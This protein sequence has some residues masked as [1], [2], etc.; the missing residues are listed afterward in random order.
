MKSLSAK[1]VAVKSDERLH[2]KLANEGL[3]SRREIESWIKDG[4]LSV[5]GKT[6]Q[7][8]QTWRAGMNLTLDGKLLHLSQKKNE[9]RVLLYHKPEGEICTRKDPQDRPTVF[10]RL[11][12]I[13]GGRWISVGRLDIN[14]AGLLLFTNDG[15]LARYLMHP[16]ANIEREY[17][18][19]VRGVVDDALLERLKRG[20]MLEDGLACF[21]DI[22]PASGDDHDGRNSWFYVT[23]KRGRNREVR[24]LWES[25][26]IQVSRLKRIRFGFIKLPANLKRGFWR[27]L[28][29]AECKTLF[30]K[31][32]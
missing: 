16:S 7:L 31:A 14:S 30:G 32:N 26:D 4:R 3:G 15:E 24:R 6:A 19:R 25:Q 2:K 9:L 12:V 27:E 13:S 22:H 10:D 23:L 8:G 5:N 11:P 29:V 21:D 1:T 28:G 20:V 17:L 18:A